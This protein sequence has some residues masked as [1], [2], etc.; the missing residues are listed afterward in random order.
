MP[1][2]QD[3][4]RDR[5]AACVRA[6]VARRKVPQRDIAARLGITQQAVSRRLSGHVPFAAH[7]LADLADLLDVSVSDLVGE[8]RTEA[9]S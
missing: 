8:H 5:I 6:E 7:E 2:Q 1:V 9:A 4:S 3:A